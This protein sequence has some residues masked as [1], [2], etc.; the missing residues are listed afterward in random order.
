MDLLPGAPALASAPAQ[1]DDDVLQEGQLFL[2]KLS[3]AA[4]GVGLPALACP[5]R[6]G[7][8]TPLVVG[9]CGG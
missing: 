7:W 3:P 9:A 2:G 1:Q 5:P 8:P 4:V 6:V